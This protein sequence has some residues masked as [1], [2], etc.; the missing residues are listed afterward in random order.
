MPMFSLPSKNGV[1]DMGEGAYEFVDILAESGITIWQI[2]PLNP[3]GYG[4]SP[5]QPY[6]SYAGD[7]IYINLEL[8]K[9]DGLIKSDIP[10]FLRAAN[11][12]DYKAV[13][14]FKEPFFAEAFKNFKGNEEYLSFAKQKWVRQYCTYA[15]IRKSEGG[16]CWI[17]WK[18]ELKNYPEKEIKLSDE[19]ERE[20]E[21][22]I[23]LQ[24]EF[25]IQWRNIKKYANEKGIRIMGDVPFYVGLDS[26]DV[27]SNKKNFLLDDDGRPSFVAGVPPDY[28]S[29]TGQRWG[30][31]IYDWDY[32]K[33]DNFKFWTDRMGFSAELF[34][35]IRIDHF[36]A[37]DTYWSIP[38]DCPTAIDGEWIENCGYEAIEEI[39][40][41]ISAAELV[42]EDLGEL[43][44]EVIE[45]RDNFN[46]KGMKVLMFC[47]NLDSKCASDSFEKKENLIV[48]TGTHDNDTVIEWYEKLSTAKKRKLRRFF[49]RNNLKEGTLNDKMILYAL[50]SEA[51]Y[52]IIS[53]P[54]LLALGREGHINTPG[55]VGSPNW[56]Y[57]EPDFSRIKGAFKRYS[58][59]I[60]RK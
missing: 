21:Y 41:N 15:A 42:A 36:R 46:L 3:A 22:N 34:D 45:L 51:Q 30:N 2:L 9:R 17:D 55:T 48:Y 5:Y 52:A 53:M 16:K 23:F 57:R 32:I 20:I 1:G 39:K 10:D 25:Y 54:D 18:E 19:I 50:K 12:V 26:A 44:Q 27:W 28:F 35:I 4:N 60:N 31:P 49:R 11:R 13:R 38:S 24:Y 37:F 33:K 7:N 29:K 47:L 40:K 43:R 56:E 6:S 8:L 58:P 14:D 59:Y